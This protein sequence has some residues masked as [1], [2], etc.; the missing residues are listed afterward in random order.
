[1]RHITNLDLREYNSYRITAHCANTFFPE[2][3]EDLRYLYTD[4][5]HIPKILLGS[6][7]NVILSKPYYPEDFVIFSGNF[8][9]IEIQNTRVTAEAGATML[10]VSEQ[11]LASSLTGL[12]IFYDIPSSVGGAVVMN[13]GASGEEIKDVLVKVSYY[14]TLKNTFG[15]LEKDQIGFQYRNSVFQQNPHLIVT[16]AW[17]ELKPGQKD[18]IKEKMD[19]IKEARWAKQPRDFPNAGSIFKRPKGYY[20]GTMIE[21]LGLKGYKVGGAMISEKHGGFI[22]NVNNATGK[23]ILDLVG[24]CQRKVWENFNVELEMEQRVI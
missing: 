2:T 8:N 24:V 14:D 16:K 5:K 13:A 12:E 19:C 17:L 21:E 6:G 10:E 22:V 18:S 15:E 23:D 20:V 4:R 9:K 3:E 11:T 7:H 1:M